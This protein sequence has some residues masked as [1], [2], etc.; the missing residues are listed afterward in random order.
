MSFFYLKNNHFCLI[1]NNVMWT[2]KALN[3]SEKEQ[4]VTNRAAAL[5]PGRRASVIG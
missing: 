2:E 4:L 3:L 1:I 5:Q